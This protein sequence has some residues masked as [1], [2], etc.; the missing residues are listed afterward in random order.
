MRVK[1][2]WIFPKKKKTCSR[3]HF[4]I[5]ENVIQLVPL[6]II[7]VIPFL[8]KLPWYS[9]YF[10]YTQKN[11]SEK[12][13]VTKKILYVRFKSTFKNAEPTL[14]VISGFCWGHACSWLG[15]RDVK[16]TDPKRAKKCQ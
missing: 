16:S 11:I 4:N 7:N 12:P 5:H 9:D 2:P 10:L 3:I 1:Q 13:E 6:I 15:K 14:C 8:H